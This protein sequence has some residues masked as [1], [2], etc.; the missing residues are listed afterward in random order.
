M[1]EDPTEY[2]ERQTEL[3]NRLVTLEENHQRQIEELLDFQE[4][5][6]QD[7]A[8]IARAANLYFWLTV[9]GLVG[10]VLL[11]IINISVV[12]SFLRILPILR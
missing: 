2:L 3:L 5:Y 6:S 12:L 10:S 1:P 7:L 4:D 11:L 8:S 9:I